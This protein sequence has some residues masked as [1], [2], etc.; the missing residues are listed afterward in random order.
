MAALLG[1][2]QAVAETL[3]NGSLA[4]ADETQEISN[5]TGIESIPLNTPASTTDM[6][7]GFTLGAEKQRDKEKRIDAVTMPIPISNPTIGSGL[8]FG[9]MLLYQLDENS[10][11]SST[12]L[13]G[14]YTDT[15]SWGAGISQK[16][17][18]NNDK[19]RVNATAGYADMNLK[20]YGIGN[21][22][23]GKE[24]YINLNQSGYLI[25]ARFQTEIRDNLYFGIGYKY[26]S[27]TTR[28]DLNDIDA[29]V[30][31]PTI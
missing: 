13:G 9:T 29:G 15:S 8:A 1:C 22:S 27:L 30:D 31:L 21:N 25:N 10:P 18:F 6:G 20:F 17:Y 5:T 16:A 2:S 3:E 11:A 28:I 7:S 12:T 26:L 19:Y 4:I 23:G 24:Q 14:L